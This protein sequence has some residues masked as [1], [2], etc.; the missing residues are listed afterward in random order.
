[1]NPDV[2]Q[3]HHSSVIYQKLLEKLTYL[4]TQLGEM[5]QDFAF[6]NRFNLHP[7]RISELGW[8]QANHFLEFVASGND[9][10]VVSAGSY[11]ME[12]GL[13]QSTLAALG[14][15]LRRF[16]RA[17][18]PVEGSE[19]MDQGLDLVDRYMSSL[20]EGYNTALEARILE[21]QEQMR[22]AL[23]GAL[24][25][26]RRELYIKNHAINTSINGIMLTD[27]DGRITYVNPAFS[28]MWGLEDPSV[29]HGKNCIDLLEIDKSHEIV[30][31]LSEKAGAGWRGELRARRA[32]GSYFEVE[33]SLSIIKDVGRYRIG[34][35]VSFVDIT[36]RKRLEA[37]FREAKK[38]EAI[39]T[40]AS[41]I[42]HDFNNLLTTIQG[43]TSLMLLSMDRAHPFYERLRSIEKQVE[44]GS[45]LTT[46]LLGYARK[47]R[48]EVKPVDLNRLVEDLA[49][50][51]NRTRKELSIHL[52]LDKH[53][54]AIEADA[55]QIEQVLLNLYINAADAMPGGGNLFIGTKNLSYDQVKGKLSNPKK[56]NYVMINIA[57]TGSGMTKETMERVFDPFFTTKEMGRG[58][59]LG[60][61]VVYGIV[62]GH[63]GYIKVESEVGKGTTFEIYLPASDRVFAQP[64]RAPEQTIKGNE[65]ILCVDDERAV[66][67]I[68]S[69]LLQAL[70]YQVLSANSGREA[71]EIYGANRDQISLV[72][73]D[74][75][76]PEMGGGETYDA[77][78]NISS[79]VKV[80]LSTGYS[81]E[82]KATDIMNRGCNG[83]IQKPFKLT[84]LSKKVRE[85]LD[86]STM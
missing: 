45:R 28:D 9:K 21:D 19:L 24:E 73:L 22:R 81:I 72:I 13:G 7:R 53:L 32:N 15:R 10:E 78:R 37:D 51:F 62:K 59:G 41:G 63:G 36:E 79:K 65:T 52:E 83:F 84:A 17:T 71:V 76:M 42:A 67:S 55:G 56:S 8:E 77:L 57:D 25:S 1:M 39:G 6:E 68:A 29:V 50:T 18:F 44:S 35:M 46:Q 4:A 80:L 3:S 47:G 34:V 70:G 74:M 12:E 54:L 31:A 38:T 64:P 5:F 49:E 30:N 60:L 48:Y 16:C 2:R 61:A 75:I 69:E 58:T 85:I 14:V 43:H 27:I 33:V 40:L 11:R 86:E 20:M 66:L 26:Q 82:G 23:S